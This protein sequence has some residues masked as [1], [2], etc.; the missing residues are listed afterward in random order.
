MMQHNDMIV[1]RQIA[2]TSKTDA[3]LNLQV[4]AF[5]TLMKEP[6]SF[7]GSSLNAAAASEKKHGFITHLSKCKQFEIAVMPPEQLA[8]EVLMEKSAFVARRKSTQELDRL[9]HYPHDAIQSLEFEHPTKPC[10]DFLSKPTS[11][12][13]TSIME[14]CALLGNV[15]EVGD[16][17]AD[18][19]S[20]SGS[21]EQ[22]KRV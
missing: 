3:L 6:I 13:W 17:E 11:V 2:L 1:G 19:V 22:A 7:F 15:G 20:F 18:G 21:G 14:C 8:L 10:L 4:S 5:W 16:G 12:L 9:R